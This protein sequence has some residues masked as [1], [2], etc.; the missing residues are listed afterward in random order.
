[1]KKPKRRIL[2]F[3]TIPSSNFGL[4]GTSNGHC[5]QPT[6][7]GTSSKTQKLNH[8]TLNL[9]CVGGYQPNVCCCDNIVAALKVQMEIMNT[10]PLSALGT[11]NSYSEHKLLTNDNDTSDSNASATVIKRHRSWS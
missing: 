10:S 4:T 5:T 3:P 11:S 9:S 8:S 7:G 2:I 1:M 6:L